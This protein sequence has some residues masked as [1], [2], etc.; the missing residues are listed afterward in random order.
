M[1]AIWKFPFETTGLFTLEMPANAQILTVQTQ[2]EQGCI[3][4]LVDV[5]APYEHRVFNIFGT[6]H[7]ITDDSNIGY[8]GTYQQHGGALV[9]HLFEVL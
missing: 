5:D 7:D 3:W 9:F 6:G 4:A 2:N 1:K 8:I